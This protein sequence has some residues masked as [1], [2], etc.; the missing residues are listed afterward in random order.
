MDVSMEPASFPKIKLA[1]EAEGELVLIGVHEEDLKVD[2]SSVEIGSEALKGLDEKYGGALSDILLEGGFK[3][4][5]GSC[6][7]VREGRVVRFVGLLGLGS[8]EKASVDS[9]WGRC[10]Y[11]ELGEQVANGAKKHKAKSASVVFVNALSGAVGVI[12]GKVALGVWLGGY[13]ITRF[14]KDPKISPLED[15]GLVL[16]CS[17]E[18]FSPEVSRAER[19]ARGVMLARSL[20]ETPANVCTPQY[21]AD[22]AKMIAEEFPDVMKLKVLERE[23]CEKRNMGLY[24]AVAKGSALPPKFIH[25]T[26][27]P[28]NGKVNKKIALVGKGLSFDSGG[29]NIKLGMMELMKLDM[30]GASA[31]LG[32]AKILGALKPKGVEI[33]FIVAAC[34]NMIANNA[35]RPGDVLTASNKKTVEIINTDAEGRLT[36][37]DALVYAQV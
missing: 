7:I 23:E 20:V 8:K 15:L 35:Y 12:G 4:K 18:E 16:G 24:L 17:E 33:H 28:S 11:Q 6:G 37:A 14:K 36:L 32:A 26:Y 29:Y 1:K 5:P 30:G 27:T 9:E 21:M 2:G 22:T 3:G 31:T 19:V 10:V 25:L 13:E 34:E